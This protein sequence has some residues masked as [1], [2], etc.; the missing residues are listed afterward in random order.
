MFGVH[1]AWASSGV[2]PYAMNF[3]G[4]LQQNSVPASGNFAMKFSLLVSGTSVWCEELTTVS[5]SSGSFSVALGSS[6]DP[7]G[8]EGMDPTCTTSEPA[9]LELDPALVSA[10][11]SSTAVTIQVQIYDGSAWETL[12]NP[13][14][15]SSSLFALQADTAESS[16]EIQGVAV[17]STAPTSGQVLEYNSTNEDWEPTTA[18]TTTPAS[19]TS[20]IQFNSSGAFGGSSNLEWNNSQAIMYLTGGLTIDTSAT[21]SSYPVNITESWNNG[22]VFYQ[23]FLL[24]ITNNASGAGSRMVDIQL[25]GTSQFIIDSS[26]EVGI[27]NTS[28]SNLLAVGSSSVAG[29]TT[30]AS[31]ITASGTCSITPASSGSG[32]SCS[33]DERLKENV[34]DVSG[35]SAL[36]RILKTQAVAYDFKADQTKSRH[37]GYIAQ[38]LQKIAPELVRQGE[39][40]YLQVFYDGLIPWIT[41]AIKEMSHREGRDIASLKTENAELK[42]E[43]AEIKAR[44]TKIE[45]QLQTTGSK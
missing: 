25:G 23:G 14:S 34:S 5:V 22:T 33:S 17:S 39:D 11:T 45:K 29:G 43:N 10:V 30:V 31:F 37:T 18:A 8:P 13:L 42:R 3:S 24:N 19:P 2:T 9:D 7:Q 21:A 44:L 40:G 1:S 6:S 15:V 36:D 27:A 41:E 20:S 32:I 26:G 4:Y 12:S 28:P 38:A 35:D 16:N